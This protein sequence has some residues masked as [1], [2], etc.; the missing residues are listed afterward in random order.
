MLAQAAQ[1]SM[2][3]QIGWFADPL[4]FGHY[5]H[6]MRAALGERLP[7]FSAAESALLRGSVDF[8]GVN[9]YTT[10]YT[11]AAANTDNRLSMDATDRSGAKLCC[12][13]R[14]SMFDLF[15]I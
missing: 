4:F 15:W 11:T 8:I 6:D 13:Q 10:K 2:E 9:H 12:H 1:R 3:W 7:A 14:R 5:P